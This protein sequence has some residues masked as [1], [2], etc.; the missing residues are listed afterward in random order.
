MTPEAKGMLRRLRL[1]LEDWDWRHE[2]GRARLASL[3]GL[4]LVTALAAG[5][6]LFFAGKATS[7]SRNCVATLASGS[8]AINA[9]AGY[10]CDGTANSTL[11]LTG[12]TPDNLTINNG[13]IITVPADATAG[14]AYLLNNVTINSGGKLNLNDAT[15]STTGDVTVLGTYTMANGGLQ[16]W[17]N[18]AGTLELDGNVTIASGNTSA[19][20]IGVNSG[21]RVLKLAGSGNSTYDVAS[22]IYVNRLWVAVPSGTTKTFSPSVS[23]ANP[24]INVTQTGGVT[25][26]SIPTELDLG[27]GTPSGTGCSPTTPTRSNNVAGNIAQTGSPGSNGTILFNPSTVEHNCVD[28]HTGGVGDNSTALLVVGGASG[29]TVNI[30]PQG[31]LDYGSFPKMSMDLTNQTINWV[32]PLL[33]GTTVAAARLGQDLTVTNGSGTTHWSLNNM[34]FDF[35][36]ADG[37]TMTLS[38]SS[39]TWQSVDI[40]GENGNGA[41][42]GHVVIADGKTLNVN[43]NV[44]LMDGYLDVNGGGAGTGTV[45]MTG[46]NKGLVLNSA[47]DG[48]TGTIA[49]FG[50]STASGPIWLDGC[51]G[52]SSDSNFSGGNTANVTGATEHCLGDVGATSAVYPKTIT[53]DAGAFVGVQGNIRFQSGGSFANSS[54]QL[55][56]GGFS[57]SVATASANPGDGSTVT[58]H[59][60]TYRFAATP[61]SGNDVQIGASR[62]ITL[63]NL[64]AAVNGTGT[65][66]T[67]YFAGTAQPGDVVA[68]GV[69]T[70]N[71][72]LILRSHAPGTTGNGAY[73]ATASG[74]SN[75]TWT[76]GTFSGGDT[77]NAGTVYSAGASLTGTATFYNLSISGSTT[78]NSNTTVLGNLILNAVPS[79]SGTIY[80]SPP[81]STTRM[82]Q[83]DTN[84]T[85]SQPLWLNGENS[86][87]NVAVKKLDGSTNGTVTATGAVTLNS[88]TL[89]AGEID[90]QGNVSASQYFSGGAG[91]LKLNNTSAGQTFTGTQTSTA[92]DLPNVTIADTGQT[93]TLSGTVRSTKNWTFSSG[94][95]ISATGSTFYANGTTFAGSQTL[96]NLNVIANSTISS[97]TLSTGTSG[98]VT[99]A[100]GKLA[101]GANEL[102]VK[103][104]STSAVTGA[105]GTNGWVNGN[106]ERSIP[107]SGS[108]QAY[109]WD[110]GGATNYTPATTTFP[111]L[112]QAGSITMSA[113][114]A[115]ATHKSTWTLSSTNYVKRYFTVTNSAT[116]VTWSGGNANTK[117]FYVTGDI[118]N[119]A[120]EA[121]FVVAKDTDPS[122]T[123][124]WSTLAATADAVG[125]GT[126]ATSGISSLQSSATQFALG[127][128]GGPD[129]FN[130]TPAST[131]VTAGAST[132]LTITA[133]NSSNQTFTGYTGDKTITLGG[134]NN[135]PDGTVPTG[136]DKT[137]AD[138][139]FGTATTIT[140]TNGVG[141]T[142][143]K[144][145]KAETAHLTATD[146]T[147]S[148]GATADWTVNPH[149]ATR[150]VV[151]GSGTQTAGSAQTITLTAKDAWGNTDTNYSGNESITFSGANDP[152]ETSNHPTV[153][154]T[155]ASATNFGSAT[156]IHFASGVS[157]NDS[158]GSRSMILYKAETANIAAADSTNAISAS[159]GSDRLTVVVS[160]HAATRLVVTG[161]GTQTAGSAQTITLTAKDAW[162]N[163]D[164][165]FSGAK[166]IAFSGASDPLETSNHPTVTNTSASAVNFGST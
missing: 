122:G 47:F 36:P 80:M 132:T 19:N 125:H 16:Q 27:T 46:N 18:Q 151:T 131:T 85:L 26:A 93:M 117:F 133:V 32:G 38:P 160:A 154:N 136:S 7:A 119:S 64:A 55:Q 17:A 66:G 107:G 58:I 77:N 124:S 8:T 59:D 34:R 31:S 164:T 139:N 135:A 48:G 95:G 113:T 99:F 75:I 112:T 166:N 102:W 14:V 106:L 30:V 161:S 162:G 39:E 15:S 142:T 156:T 134:A 35:A 123:G 90:A 71:H 63:A 149:A 158:S 12:S 88:G 82:I 69:N 2:A 130:L 72:T 67:E 79:G 141:T 144:L 5:V 120:T 110:I 104:T 6:A 103:N 98:V 40:G 153:T 146:G 60:V 50:G 111:T 56:L 87:A 118:Q 28:A 148:Q 10:T 115:D 163:T 49:L 127:E 155:S 116:P 150:L 137:A 53:V 114:S 3:G 84:Q 23:Q 152:L 42:D 1:R 61:S 11:V 147:V 52:A 73:L 68:S 9:A 94:A 140:F 24:A 97:G 109:T 51:Y 45:K 22:T 25:G 126:T 89:S 62:D 29:S 91:T 86:N 13:Q 37:N 157:D 100:G 105:S 4:L 101:T 128:P 108:S 78:L 83:S 44:G 33:S 165:A 74:A 81:A 92:G 43:A 121:N 70:T 54:N 41:N 21:T 76:S 145:Y 143:V 65:P 138:V 159:T 57:S 96:N 20:W 129:H